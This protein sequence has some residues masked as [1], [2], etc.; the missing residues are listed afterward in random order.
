MSK[1]TF[2]H[3]RLW[4]K[5]VELYRLRLSANNRAILCSSCD[6]GFSEL[7]DLSMRTTTQMISSCTSFPLFWLA[8]LV[9]LERN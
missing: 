1:G 6:A 2:H 3:Q 9:Q 8:E 5:D 4:D 7:S